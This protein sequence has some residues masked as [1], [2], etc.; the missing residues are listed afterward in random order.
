MK[1]CAPTARRGRFDLRVRGLAVAVGDVVADRAREE[2][3]FLR[4][5]AELLMKRDGVVLIHRNAIDTHSTRRCV[6]EA[7]DELDHG[8]LAGTGLTDQRDRLA[9]PNPHVDT[10]QGLVDRR[11]VT[12]MHVLEHDFAAQLR[13]RHRVRGCGYRRLCVEQ[14]GDAVDRDARLLIGVEH[15]R[16]LLDRRKEQVEIQQ[17]RDQGADR[18]RAVGNQHGTRA[19]HQTHGDVGEEVDEREVD[20][21]R[22]AARAPARRDTRRRPLRTVP[23]C[24]LRARTPARRAHPTSLLAGSR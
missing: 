10:T 14:L 2:E 5:D 15:L 9:R 12:E 4:N 11:R 21:D 1:S 19:E 18:E 23:G 7:R 8:R 6:V 16:K 22:A 20:G 24:A 17:E 13:H 3:R